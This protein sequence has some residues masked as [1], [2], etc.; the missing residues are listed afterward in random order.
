[1]P[2]TPFVPIGKAVYGRVPIL[3][4][5][6]TIQAIPHSLPS[7]FLRKAAMRSAEVMLGKLQ[8]IKQAIS[9]SEQKMQA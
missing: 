4:A 1:M 3:A 7:I 2:F 8:K 6:T 5:L 9:G